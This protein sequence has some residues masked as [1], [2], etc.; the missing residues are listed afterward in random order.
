MCS[1]EITTNLSV[2]SIYGLNQYKS[3]Q[4]IQCIHLQCHDFT[5]ETWHVLFQM[6]MTK[7]STL[8]WL[9]SH[10]FVFLHLCLCSFPGSC[11]V[12]KYAA[13]SC[14]SWCLL[15]THIAVIL[16]CHQTKTNSKNKFEFECNKKEVKIGIPESHICALTKRWFVFFVGIFECIG[17]RVVLIL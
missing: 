17:K 1:R 15:W 7:K 9:T 13:P 12:R 16:I 8:T 2:S 5:F 6:L 4:L 3:H 11:L 10:G 14:S